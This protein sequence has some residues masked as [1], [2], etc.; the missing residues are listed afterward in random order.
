MGTVRGA[1]G[2]ALRVVI[3]GLSLTL[4]HLPTLVVIYLLGSAGRNGV[5]W[6]AINISESHSTIA[7]LLLPFAPLSTLVAFM[8]MLRVVATSLPHA[9]FGVAQHA[10]DPQT[11]RSEQLTLLASTL[12]PFLTVYAAQGYLK[13]DVNVYINA[14]VYDE[15]FGSAATFYGDSANVDRTAIASGVW[16]A[17][18]VVL[19]L[20]LRFA[21]SRFDLPRKHVGFGALAAYVEVLWILTLA[22]QFTR[23]QDSM[24]QWVLERRTVHVVQDRWAALIDVLGPVGTPIAAAARHLGSFIDSSDDL[25]LIPVAWLTVGAV[26]LGHT[27]T[28]PPRQPRERPWTKH[29]QR[30][31]SR[32][33]TWGNELTADFAKRFRGLA[34][35][36]RLLIVGGLLPM[37]L[38]CL[39]FVLSRQGGI[40]AGEIVRLIV[41]P[42]SRD[43]G[44][45]FAP[46]VEV[47]IGTVSTVLLV[48]LLG[49]AIDRTIA[50]ARRQ[51]ED[52]QPETS[53]ST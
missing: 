21:I 2:D 13:E 50:R 8:L 29:V 43:T 51:A 27:I 24:W 19:A 6:A 10:D 23:Y 45:A 17:G 44:I 48:G 41:G 46:W 53:T 32:L 37:L 22:G 31:P 34:D 4:R 36:V 12:V 30:V 26:A 14:A 5:L 16:L 35:G 39:V 3:D 33:R 9:G 20:A 49:A 25:L 42:Q 18:L 47:A 52:A 11:R 15:I 1:L 38:F 28:A 40:W 7:G